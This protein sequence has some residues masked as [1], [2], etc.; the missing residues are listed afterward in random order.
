MKL[1]FEGHFAV[2]LPRERVF[3]TIVD[4]DQVARCMP[5][6][7]RLDV[8]SEDEFSAV[9]GVGVSIIRG[10]IAL[11]FK[12]V[13]KKPPSR[14]RMLAHGTGLGSAMDVEMVTELTD[15]YDGGTSMKWTA[16]ATVSGQLG[17]VNQGLIRSQA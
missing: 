8:K 9:V 13:E 1:H 16:D 10:D 15:G 2:A 17:S 11:H 5:G 12:T 7:K 3:A 4:P 6:L 14:V